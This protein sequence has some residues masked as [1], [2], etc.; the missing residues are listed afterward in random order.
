MENEEGGEQ[1]YIIAGT[2]MSF[3]WSHIIL[4]PSPPKIKNK[5]DLISIWTQLTNIYY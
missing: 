4:P 5:G 2:L 1:N 3:V